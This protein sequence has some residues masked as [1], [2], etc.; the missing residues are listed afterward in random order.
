MPKYAVQDIAK[1]FGPT[2]ALRGV[3]L[4]FAPG[5]IHGIVGENGAGKSTLMRILSGLETPDKGS[6]LMHNQPLAL[7]SVRHSMAAGIAMVHQELNLVEDLTVAENLFLGR[8]PVQGV[9]VD[10]ARMNAEGKQWLAQVGAPFGPET[11]LGE[12]SVAHMQLVE[13]AKA[14]SCQA[15]LLILDEPTAVL[16]RD[17]VQALFRVTRDL[18]AQGKTV[19]YISHILSEVIELCGQITVMRDGQVV[20]TLPAAEVTPERLATRMVGRDLGDYYPPKNPDVGSEVRLEV[21]NLRLPGASPAVSLEVRAGEVVGLAGLVGSGRTEIAEAIAGL[22]PRAAGTVTGDQVA[23]LSEDRKG[24]GLITSM[25]SRE[26]VTM[27]DLDR[28][29]PLKLDEGHRARAT[30]RW[31]E[32]LGIKVSDIDAP[33]SALSG[34]NQQKVALAKWLQTGRKMLILDEPTRGVDVGAKREIYRAV[35]DLAGQGFGILVIS[36]EMPELIG[37]CHRILVVR[38][39]QIVTELSEQKITEGE[40]MRHA[41]IVESMA[42]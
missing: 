15:N 32:R 21:R 19:L 31:V 23:Y 12:L 6:V 34:G 24:R 36:S 26:N 25:S 41:A 2:Q 27:A 1:S 9:T 42:A 4:E 8:E 20:A 18:A 17:E 33:V 30:R 29:S 40:I 38:Q 35:A 5:E 13:I 22:R 28:F 39:G 37:L 16:S 11:P 3:S 10:R 14:L 7:S